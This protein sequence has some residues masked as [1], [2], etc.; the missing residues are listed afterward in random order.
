MAMA[1]IKKGDT[2]KVLSGKDKGKTSVVKKVL[3]G[4]VWLEGLNLVHIFVKANPQQ[5]EPGGIKKQEAPLHQCKV[6]LYDSD[7]QKTINVGFQVQD[8]G[9]KVRINKKTGQVIDA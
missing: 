6:A 9:K 2:V 7:T 8:D 4:K 3:D 1:K 5:D